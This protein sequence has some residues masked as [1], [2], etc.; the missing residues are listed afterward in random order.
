MSRFNR[1]STLAAVAVIAALALA[2]AAGAVTAQTKGKPERGTVHFAITH[3]VGK[4][5]IS[6]GDVTDSLFGAGAVVFHLH[7]LPNSSGNLT[8]TIQN[9]TLFYSTG[10]ASGTATATLTITNKPQSGDATVTRGVIK[11]TKGFGTHKG[12]TFTGTFSGKGNVNGG[13]YTINYKGTYK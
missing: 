3:T 9:V 2:L 1:R 6:A 7:V 11:L 10:S 8:I 13:T 5:N 4:V 12:H